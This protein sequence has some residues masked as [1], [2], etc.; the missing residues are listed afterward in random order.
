MHSRGGDRDPTVRST[1]ASRRNPG[2][3]C[4]AFGAPRRRRTADSSTERRHPTHLDH[5]ATVAHRVLPSRQGPTAP[6]QDPEDFFMST[7]TRRR[8]YFACLVLALALGASGCDLYFGPDHSQDHYTYCDSTGCYDC[9]GG[10]CTPQGGSGYQCTSSTQC[11]AGCYCD[12][13]TS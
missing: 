6:L 10:V 7:S 1:P 11:A 3:F 2:H 4:Q 13:T 8:T 12:L 5:V 9:T